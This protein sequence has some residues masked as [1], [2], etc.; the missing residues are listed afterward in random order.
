MRPGDAG[1]WSGSVPYLAGQPQMI[2]NRARNAIERYFGRIK[3][4][5]GI[6]S[7]YHK[8]AHVYINRII[9]AGI[10]CMTK[11]SQQALGGRSGRGYSLE[12]TALARPKACK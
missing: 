1:C 9:L 8:L 2:A 3:R 11:Q 5:R 12:A 10:H 7:R 4:F 6:A